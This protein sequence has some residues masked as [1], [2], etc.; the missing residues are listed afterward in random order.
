MANIGDYLPQ[1]EQDWKRYDD[2][3][4]NINY[5]GDNWTFFNEQF[6]GYKKTI[7][8][9]ESSPNEEE[10]KFNFTGSKIRLIDFITSGRG[11]R[12]IIIDNIKYEYSS[13][14]SKSDTSYLVFEKFDLKLVSTQ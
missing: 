10:I 11:K 1:A 9:V 4:K 13:Q 8:S 14:G 12:Q 2:T 7:H 6:N 3:D 5:I